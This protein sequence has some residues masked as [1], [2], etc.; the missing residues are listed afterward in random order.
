MWQQLLKQCQ[1]GWN[2]KRW[3]LHA[4]MMKLQ[5]RVVELE[6]QLREARGRGA[7]DA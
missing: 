3:R 6:E 5:Q 2:A 4:Q 7:S 1:K